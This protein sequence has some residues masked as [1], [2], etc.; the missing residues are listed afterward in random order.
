MSAKI[1]KAAN[2]VIKVLNKVDE[3]LLDFGNKIL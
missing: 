3:F 2:N 1:E